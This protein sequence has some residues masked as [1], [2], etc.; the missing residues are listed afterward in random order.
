MSV[1]LYP[2]A[3]LRRLGVITKQLFQNHWDSQ[4]EA[5]PYREKVEAHTGPKIKYV[6]DKPSSI[7][8]LII[9]ML[10]AHNTQHENQQ[11]QT[12]PTPYWGWCFLSWQ[13]RLSSHTWMSIHI[14]LP[15]T[16][17]GKDK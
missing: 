5:Y 4:L 11:D 13:L 1:R 14:S 8:N 17:N 6:S 2:N 3:A 7:Q 10:P 15:F 12:P 16:R 9:L